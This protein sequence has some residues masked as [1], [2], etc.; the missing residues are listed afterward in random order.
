MACR[1]NVEYRAVEL[2]EQL[3]SQKV[4]DLAIKY[5]ARI[6]RTALMKK[7]ESIADIKEQGEQEESNVQNDMNNHDE[8]I[9]E[10]T[11][12]IILTPVI[13]KKPDIEIKPLSMNQTLSMRRSNPFL[14]NACSQSIA[15]KKKDVM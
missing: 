8:T 14:K 5:A 12:E 3:A 9:V 13:T 1:S 6:N 15:G 7:L 10:D 2:C 4:L 11:E